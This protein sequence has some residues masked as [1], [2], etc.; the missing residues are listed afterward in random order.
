M[1]SRM[2]VKKLLEGLVERGRVVE[3]GD[4]TR[5]DRQCLRVHC[6]VRNIATVTPTIGNFLSSSHTTQEDV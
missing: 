5:I 6:L 1:T 2:A 3:I 4:V